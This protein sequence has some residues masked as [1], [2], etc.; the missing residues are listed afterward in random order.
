MGERDQLVLG[1]DH[2]RHR[3]EIDAMV[4]GQRHDVDL[5]A[6]ASCQGTMLL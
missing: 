5:A 2:R 6:P 4:G 3:V 1:P